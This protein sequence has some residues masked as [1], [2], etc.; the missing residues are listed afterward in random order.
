MTHDRRTPILRSGARGVIGAMAMSG[1]R[2]LSTALGLVRNVPPE[3]VL[4]RTAPQ[5]LQ[6]IPVDRR[7][8]LVEFVHWSYGAAGGA[9]FGLMPESVRRHRWAGPA[10]G[11]AFWAIF[12]A[13]VA[14]VLGLPHKNTT[15]RE[16]LSLLGDHLLY[17][18]V[19]AAS[20][21][22]HQDH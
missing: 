13:A 2:Q 18:V 14:P 22:P 20:P 12:Q 3:S 11:L 8:A 7:P 6:R 19:V 10:Y 17:G 15:T 16:R 9:L 4:E 1:L 21:W 5:L